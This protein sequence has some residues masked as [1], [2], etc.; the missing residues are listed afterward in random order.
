MAREKQRSVNEPLDHRTVF[1]PKQ[2]QHGIARRHRVLADLVLTRA[3]VVDPIIGIDGLAS[4]TSSLA[5]Q[6]RVSV[7][8]S[9]Q[10]PVRP[11]GPASR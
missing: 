8:M 6:D 5:A 1:P 10:L 4:A 3:P 2:R 7:R 11:E 9:R